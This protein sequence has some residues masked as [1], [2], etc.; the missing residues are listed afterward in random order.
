VPEAERRRRAAALGRLRTR[1]REAFAQRFVGQPVTVLIEGV[2]AQ[3]NARGWTGEYLECRVA[4]LTRAALAQ[5][6]AC[7]PHAAEGGALLARR[8]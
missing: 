1:Q 5:L 7:T 8:T 6:V 3:G 4:G 2:D